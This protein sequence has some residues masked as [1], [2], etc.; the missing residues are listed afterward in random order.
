ML[1]VGGKVEFLPSG[2]AK[3]IWSHLA[4]KGND[5]TIFMAV[6]TIYAR[7]L[8]EAFMLDE[9]TLQSA[10]SNIGKMRVTISGSA[11]LPGISKVFLKY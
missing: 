5:I 1:Y 3:T 10:L 7:M 6:P 9:E 2:N 11:A 4:S 8:E